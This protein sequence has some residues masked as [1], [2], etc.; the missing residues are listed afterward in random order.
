MTCIKYAVLLCCCLCLFG[1][2]GQQDSLSLQRLDEVVVTDTR[3]PIAREASGKTVIR[4][5]RKVLES[6]RGNSVADILNRQTGIEISGSR[7]RPGEV[8]GVFARGGRGRQVLVLIDGMRVS[9]PSSF[10]QEFDLRLLQADQ[11]ESIEILKGAS[12]TLYGTNAAT[13]VINITTRKAA[14]RPLEVYLQNQTGTLGSSEDDL[15]TWGQF[16]TNVGLS[17]TQGKW[18]YQADFGHQLQNGLSSLETEANE[19]DTYRNVQYSAGLSWAPTPYTQINLTANRTEM[20]S[21]YDD[22]FNRTDADFVFLTDQ[23]RIALSAFHQ[24]GKDRF[25]AKIAFASYT[26]ENVSDFPGEFQGDNWS[27]ELVYKREWSKRLYTLA[28]L[29]LFTDRAELEQTEQF[30]L[31]DPFIN[32]VWQGPKGVNINAGA[33]Y[34]FHSQYGGAGVYQINPSWS[35]PAGEGYFKI[36]GSWATSYLTPS[37]VQLYGAFGANPDLEPERNRTL[38]GGLEWK[39]SQK[40]RLNL[41]YFGRK[42]EDVVLFDNADFI[43]FN[44]D[45]TFQARGVE[46]EFQWDWSQEWSLSANYAFTEREGD[47]AIRIPKH[48]FNSRLS[49]TP[50]DRLSTWISYRFTGK[51]TDTDFTLQENVTLDAF[52]LWDARISYTW[53]E[54]R[55]QAFLGITNI[56]NTDFT[57]VIGFQTPGRN[58][59]MGLS[60]RL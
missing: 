16:A 58:L 1:L 12:S 14:D 35:L 8:L 17:G 23:D 42:E 28:G 53:L 22:S 41:I 13:A 4:L 54:N 24:S 6:Y 25:E 3:F 29:F 51:R 59:L 45:D 57:E 48:K 40:L 52:S 26:S 47:A 44:A 11:I 20:K 43:Y 34:N 18:S 5:D 19:K 21:A 7:G 9:D 10:S 36:L 15:F 33:R 37:L 55:L 2:N 46:G 50:N 49:Y 39:P 32:L 60:V 31:T 30:T 56:F 38:E 27:A